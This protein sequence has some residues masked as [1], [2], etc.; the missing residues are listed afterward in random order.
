MAKLPAFQFY[1]GDWRKDVGVQ[2]LSF[3]DRGVWWEMLCL[4]HE[5]ERR[6]VMVLNGH[7]MSDEAIGRLLG[8][9]NQN[10]TSALTNLLTSGVASRE[11]ET[12]AIY[13]R[14][15][16]RDENLR[17]IRTEAGNKGGNPVLLNQKPT[18]QDKQIPTP[19][20]SS[21]TSSTKQEQIPPL[22][23]KGETIKP[24]EFFDVWN[25]LCGKLPKA[26]KL[27]P[28]RIKK[29]QARVRNGLTLSRFCEA[30]RGCT[31][32]PFLSG[33]NDR[34]WTATFDWLIAN[35]ENVEKA[36]VNP[37]GGN[38]TNGGAHGR[39]SDNLEALRQSIA[40]DKDGLDGDG[41]FQNGEGGRG[42][43][44]SICAPVGKR[45]S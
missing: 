16:V 3:H 43:T 18:T 15:M 32:K 20:S 45:E 12:G 41:L 42:S 27:T 34:G 31:A 29:I 35:D 40:E 28:G 36:I 23:P 25:Q 1:P 10:L 4:M 24:S 9:D 33:N 38:K 6:G 44:L 17:K 2:S 7:A 11:D 13:S 19:S 39:V 22:P 5:S 14:R 21:S 8:L 26:E 30:V 37:Y